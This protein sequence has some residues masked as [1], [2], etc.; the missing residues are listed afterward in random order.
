MTVLS[1]VAP[2]VASVDDLTDRQQQILAFERKWWQYPGAKDTAIRA[3][4]DCSATR[5]QQ[6]L[7]HLIDLEAA[8][9]HD[10]MLIKRLRRL[11]DTRRARR[12]G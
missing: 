7:R 5:Y 3:L 6:E 1:D 9:V 2:T 11:R 8:Y 10:P 12:T 4:F